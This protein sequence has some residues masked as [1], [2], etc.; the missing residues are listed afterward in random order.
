M[1][2]PICICIKIANFLNFNIYNK[3]I[4]KK[5]KKKKKIKKKKKKKKVNL[6]S[7]RDY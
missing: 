3:S 6:I 5:K 4:M 2:F 7:I 1:L